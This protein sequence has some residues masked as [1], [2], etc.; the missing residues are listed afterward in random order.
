MSQSLAMSSTQTAAAPQEIENPESILSQGSPLSPGWIHAITNLMDHPLT[1]E[2]GQRIQKW[3]LSQAILDCTNLVITWD[4]I[5]FEEN[6]HLQKY[7]ESDGSVTCLQSNIVKQLIGL[8]N[9]M[10]QLISQYRPA[11]QKYSAF[12]FIL[13]EQWF[14]LTTH[15]MR[16]AL[17]NAVFENHRSQETPGTPISHVPSPSSSASMRSPIHSELASFKK[18]IKE[19]ASA[20]SILKD[21]C[22][23]DKFQRDL[24]KTA[25]SHDVSEILD[26]TF[27]PGPSPEEKELFEAKQIFMYK[28][29]DETYMGRTKVRK[30]LRTKD[31]E[32]VW[33]EYSEYMTTASKEASEKRK[34]THYVTNTVLDSQFRGTSQQF[35]LHFNEQFRRLDE[36]TDLSERM[37]ESMKMALLQNAVKD[38]PQLSIVETL[39][40]IPPQPPTLH[41]RLNGIR[42]RW[43]TNLSKWEVHSALPL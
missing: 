4:P 22:Y 30:H 9:Y 13:G 39:D 12:H 24:F 11:D 20:Y 37:P 42:T 34:Q 38:I 2:I 21:E 35:V 26:P 5:E 41:V 31:A 17:V 33:K 7:E 28:V 27:T 32:A 29:F 40:D 8:R 25:K 3:I 15:D 18:G 43:M 1:S 36:L 16:S 10:I 19:E 6:R 14:N 23:F